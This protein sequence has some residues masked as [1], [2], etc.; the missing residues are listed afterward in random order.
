[1]SKWF[2]QRQLFH[3]DPNPGSICSFGVVAGEVLEFFVTASTTSTAGATATATA[4]I[5]NGTCE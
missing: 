1:M 4:H 5:F 2:V 3:G